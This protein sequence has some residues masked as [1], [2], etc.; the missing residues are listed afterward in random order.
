MVRRST[1]ARRFRP[2]ELA[3]NQLSFSFQNGNNPAIDY[4][5]ILVYDTVAEGHAY[6]DEEIMAVTVIETSAFQ[7][8]MFYSGP[9]GTT[10][11]STPMPWR[12]I[13]ATLIDSL[14]VSQ[15]RIA[16]VTGLLDVKQS[17]AGA[18]ALND[19]AQALRDTDDNNGAF[20]IVE[21]VNDWASYRDRWWS[22]IQRQ[23]AS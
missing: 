1:A 22:Q 11:P 23:Q 16:A 9:G 8:S 14:A 20:V 7:S 4:P 21:Q 10:L 18:A 2:Q 13:A 3:A 15:A 12:R 19:R 5:R 17:L 6:E